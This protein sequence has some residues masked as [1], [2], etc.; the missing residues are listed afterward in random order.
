MKNSIFITLFSALLFISCSNDDDSSNENS[1]TLAS[2]NEKIFYNGQLD[3]E[4]T[5]HFSYENG[6]LKAMAN[7]D[8]SY[9]L[10]FTYNN[11]KVIAVT[12]FYN[13][14]SDEIQYFTYANNNLQN[15]TGEDQRATFNYSGLTL[16]NISLEYN[17]G[18]SW[19]LFSSVD[20]S[21]TNGNIS[22]KI[23]QNYSNGS[24]LYTY[25]TS[26]DYNNKMNPFQLLPSELR[27]YLSFESLTNPSYNLVTQQIGYAN[28]TDTQG[29]I[30][31]T[32]E[33]TYNSENL[34]LTIKKY[35]VSN[36]ENTLVS[37][38]IL[39]YNE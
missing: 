33:Y 16:Q 29:Y 18:S 7:D 6:K 34:P 25:K 8:N 21:F 1:I 39:T 10:E 14:S 30:T 20:Y 19:M 17:D 35:G 4:N 11:D 28:V 26:F 5:A 23:S 37:E 3:S 27:Y 15:I 32:Y 12:D 24:L 38:M 9:R 36:G 22:S 13:N 2:I 31:H